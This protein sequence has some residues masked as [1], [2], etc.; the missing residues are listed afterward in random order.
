M[1]LD[2]TF[3]IRRFVLVRGG[4]RSW[5][6]VKGVVMKAL[7]TLILMGVV[8]LV[9]GGLSAVAP[10]G[11]LPFEQDYNSFTHLLSAGD[12]VAVNT[13]ADGV[14]LILV[15]D[16]SY[17][18]RAREQRGGIERGIVA[19]VGDDYVSVQ[20][21]RKRAEDLLIPQNKTRL[22]HLPIHAIGNI[23]TFVPSQY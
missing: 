4:P 15:P 17:W 20:L 18:Q 22:L 11:S 3:R 12:R 7:R 2:A 1:A 14:E 13:F 21:I 19:D 9:A 10:S 8:G 5:D 16:D 23:T 6:D